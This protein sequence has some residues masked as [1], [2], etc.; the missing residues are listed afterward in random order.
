[1]IPRAPTAETVEAPTQFVPKPVYPRRALAAG[2]SGHV[3]LRFS[4][5]GN[6]IVQDILVVSVEP[7]GW[8]F[9][10]AAIEALQRGRYT[11]Q[12]ING[13]PMKTTGHR[14]EFAF[15]LNES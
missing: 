7:K 6:G 2:R 13:I 4:I 14:V 12:R 9:E 15:N 8:K 5:D 11:P 1:M 10:D 3:S